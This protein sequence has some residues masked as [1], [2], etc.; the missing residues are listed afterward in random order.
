MWFLG[1]PDPRKLVGVASTSSW[2]IYVICNNRCFI[3]IWKN[4]TLLYTVG[5]YRTYIL[6]VG[7]GSV[8]WVFYISCNTVVWRT[9]HPHDMIIHFSCYIKIYIATDY[10]IQQENK[11]CCLYNTYLQT[12]SILQ[13]YTICIILKKKKTP[14]P[15]M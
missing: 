11:L 5:Y 1:C 6:G 14:T 7:I 10:F 12:Y 9:Y 3:R 15:K 8:F 13:Y 2:W 4:I